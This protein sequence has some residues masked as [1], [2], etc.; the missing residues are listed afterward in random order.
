MG[1]WG[2]GTDELGLVGKEEPRNPPG[3]GFK[4]IN[5]GVWK[6]ANCDF[7]QIKLTSLRMLKYLA[8]LGWNSMGQMWRKQKEAVWTAC[9]ANKMKGCEWAQVSNQTSRVVPDDPWD[10]GPEMWTNIYSADQISPI[11][12]TLSHCSGE[13][14]TALPPAGVYKPQE[15]RAVV[16]N[17]FNAA[18]I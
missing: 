14:V 17:I 2:V 16:F 6:S 12:M 5:K 18:T 10:T 4:G 3:Y 13:R 9:L 11:P 15:T 8:R 1:V 7:S